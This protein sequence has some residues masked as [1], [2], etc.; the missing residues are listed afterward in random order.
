[1][2]YGPERVHADKAYATSRCRRFPHCLHV[3]MRIAQ[4][5]IE[6]K[7]KLGC[8]R[9]VVERTMTW[10]AQLRYLTVRDER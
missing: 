4:N 1:M 6:S 2:R 8:R 3:T 7:Q 5:G 10:L 9:W